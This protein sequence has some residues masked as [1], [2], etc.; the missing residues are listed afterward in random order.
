MKREHLHHFTTDTM[1]E[2][3]APQVKVKKNL[4]ARILNG[5]MQRLSRKPQPLNPEELSGFK[6]AQLPGVLSA[7][8]SQKSK[9]LTV[10]AI[11][12]ANAFVLILFAL[13]LYIL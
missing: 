10:T 5:A 8:D 7:G 9:I 2:P 6:Q 13:L 11:V 12:A 3:A 4:R 1:A